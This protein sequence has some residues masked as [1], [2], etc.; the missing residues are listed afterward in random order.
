MSLIERE[1]IWNALQIDFLTTKRNHFAHRLAVSDELR[2]LLFAQFAS[3]FGK[4]LPQIG[5]DTFCIS[6]RRIKDGFHLLSY[7]TVVWYGIFKAL[8]F[9]DAARVVPLQSNPSSFIHLLEWP[10]AQLT[11]A[12][13]YVD[14]LVRCCYAG[15]VANTLSTRV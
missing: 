12:V 13:S 1:E 8:F 2:L 10:A 11:G 6:K 7:S 3:N 5:F 15:F 4:C 9:L 14:T